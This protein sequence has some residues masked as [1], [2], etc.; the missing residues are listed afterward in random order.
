MKRDRRSPR[1]RTRAPASTTYPESSEHTFESVCWKCVLF[2]TVQGSVFFLWKSVF[3]TLSP[4]CLTTSSTINYKD[5][6]G[7]GPCDIPVL[8]VAYIPVQINNR[9]VS[10][11][12]LIADI[13]GEETLLG[14][15]FLTHGLAHLDFGNHSIVLFEVVPY[16]PVPYCKPRSGFNTGFTGSHRVWLLWHGGWLY[17][18]IRLFVIYTWEF[19]NV[20]IQYY[21]FL[22]FILP[23]WLY[24]IAVSYIYIF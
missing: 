19:S 10:R 13:A 8:G 15:P 16:F 21:V 22:A 24:S 14:H 5:S 6:D 4:R 3:T 20:F 7:V 12:L 17:K 1:K 11:Y 18:V 9:Q 23:K 2:W